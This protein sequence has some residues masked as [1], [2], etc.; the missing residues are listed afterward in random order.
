MLDTDTVS[1]ALRGIGNVGQR[2]SQM[3]PSELCLSA[4]T[5]AELRYGADRRGS[6]A[7]HRMIDTVSQSV[8]VAPFDDRAAERYGRLRSELPMAGTRIGDLDTLIA[9]HALA[10]DVT[11]VTNNLRHFA[12]AGGLRTETWT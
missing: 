8:W 4:I 1:Y 7:L 5:L 11:L 6:A 2:L 3:K 12:R 10:L 9:S